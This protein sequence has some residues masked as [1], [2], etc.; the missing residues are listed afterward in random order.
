MSK[1]RIAL[2]GDIVASRAIKERVTF[3]EG[4]LAC[5]KELNGE[6]RSMNAKQSG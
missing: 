1:N 5:L 2:V 4:L 3:D 6:N